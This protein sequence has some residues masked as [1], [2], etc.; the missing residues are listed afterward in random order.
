M[1]DTTEQ[2]V[3]S[4]LKRARATLK[5]GLPSADTPAA[6]RPNSPQEQALL[7]RFVEAFEAADI[8]GIV[9][10]LTED[11]W[12]RM[13]PVPLEYQGRDLAAQFFATVSFRRGRRFRLVPTRANGQPAFAAYLYDPVAA[14]GRAHGL[15][16]LTVT[17]D[18]LSAITGFDNAVFDRFGVPGILAD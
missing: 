10:C 7:F 4:A 18:H 3:Y 12:V 5:R 15:L 17:G 2:S 9:A 1:L 8:A 6:P 11:V 16:V 13:P 14:V